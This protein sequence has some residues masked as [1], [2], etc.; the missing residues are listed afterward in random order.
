LHRQHPEFG[1]AVP[2]RVE[3]ERDVRAGVTFR[4]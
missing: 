2:H 4:F 3:I 1:A